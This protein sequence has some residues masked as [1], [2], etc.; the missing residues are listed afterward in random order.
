[1][2]AT[3][4]VS[5]TAVLMAL[6]AGA[7]AASLH[8]AGGDF[9]MGVIYP[10]QQA[11]ALQV[12]DK[13]LGGAKAQ[14]ITQSNDEK[15][16]FQ[17]GGDTFT[18]FK[19]AADRSCDN[20]KNACAELSNSKKIDAPVSECDRQNTECKAAAASATQTAFN[21][22]VSSNAEFDFFCDL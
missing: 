8:L 5:A 18:D 3:R 9:R 21:A 14:E 22:L 4:L 12:F 19:S 16:P 2:F 17:L 6:F 1:M 7:L 13:A 20:Q 11:R 15:R 10:R